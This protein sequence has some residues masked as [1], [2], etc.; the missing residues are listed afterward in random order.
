[1]TDVNQRLFDKPAY[2][3]GV[4]TAGAATISEIALTARNANGA[5]VPGAWFKVYLSDSAAGIAYTATTA[6]GTVTVKT[7]GTTGTIMFTY[8]AK[9]GLLVQANSA[10]SFTLQIT[11]S[12]RTAF[13][14]CV[15]IEGMPMVVKTLAT[16]SYGA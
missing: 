12:A 1:M 11:D 7:A 10:G 13:K 16:A 2:V 4:V 8:L 3:T 14:V 5:P 9:F 15:E 6:S